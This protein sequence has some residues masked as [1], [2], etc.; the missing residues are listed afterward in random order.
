LTQP[1]S[2]QKCNRDTGVPPVLAALQ[3]RIP[4]RSLLRLAAASPLLAL[5]PSAG[6]AFS[7]TDDY[8]RA[9]A[10]RE[11]SFPRDHGQHPGFKTE[12]WY[13]TGHLR[14]AAG[15]IFGYQL[16]FFRTALTPNPAPRPSPWAATDLFLAHA[17]ISDVQ[18]QSL[19]YA[20]R[21]GR[22]RTGYAAASDSTLDLQLKDWSIKPVPGN[23]WRLLAADR[24]K[25]FA[26]DLT[27][28]FA[29]RPPVLQGPG[30]LNPKGNATG[31][32]S[33]YYSVTRLPT[34]GTLTLA[35]TRHQ[36][37]GQSW[38]DHEFASNSLA[39]DQVG[40]DWLALN[41]AAGEDVML[42]RL[43]SNSNQTDYLSGTLISKDGQATYLTAGEIGFTPVGEWKS[44]SGTAYPA[45]WSVKV[46]GLAEMTIRPRM[47][48]Q[49][50][51]TPESTDV[52]YYEGAVEA[53][54]ARGEAVGEGYL[55]MT[56]YAKPVTR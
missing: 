22:G 26:L 21:L 20:E 8:L 46:K 1:P 16:T 23:N 38:M 29:S 13:F 2:R 27:L 6:Q 30:G 9:L 39:A 18:A 24:A 40:W 43:R 49:E 3:A 33:Y 51:Q 36:V 53:V 37:T 45:K 15:R 7:A 32:A 55:E 10:P 41:L 5:V 47:A 4:R 28:P 52:T 11:W 35:N 17:A 12:W 56:G 31:Q 14:T 19:L 50:L 48:D 54:G 42:Y 25:Q 44:S 34:S